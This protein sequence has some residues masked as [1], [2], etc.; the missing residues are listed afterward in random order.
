[1]KVLEWAEKHYPVDP[2]RVYVVGMS[3]G[4]YGTIDF[5]GT[6]PD[7]VAAAMALCGGGTIKDYSGLLKVPLW[8]IHGKSD[9]QVPWTASQKVVDAMAAIDTTRLLRY[10]LLPGID[11]G[12]L[13][14]CFYVK[15]T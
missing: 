6:Y 13:A 12:G 8:I 14:R 5:A 2:S 3:L 15:N 4:G 9:R 10:D 11:P 1:M 7:K